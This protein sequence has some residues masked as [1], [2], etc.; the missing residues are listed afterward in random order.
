M[1]PEYSMR[2]SQTRSASARRPVRPTI[3]IVLASNQPRSTLDA[4]VS[5][6]ST[7]CTG[8][9]AELIVARADSALHL[10]VLSRLYPL[11][12]FVPAPSECSISELRTYG[13]KVA[14]G[15]IVLLL[16]DAMDIDEGFVE[17]VLGQ[18]NRQGADAS[19][20]QS[21]SAARTQQRREQLRASG[22]S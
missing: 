8:C 21:V 17:G 2:D 12:R 20:E 10:G 16:D 15:D 5:T 1:Q 14:T 22:E 9:R 11:A 18:F 19:P 4:C 7:H 6:L 3:S 13:M